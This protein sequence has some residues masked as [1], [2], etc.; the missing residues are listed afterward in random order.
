MPGF[1][2]KIR[3]IMTLRTAR[4]IANRISHCDPGPAPKTIGIGPMKTIPPMLVEAPCETIVAI[5]TSMRPIIIAKNPRM[6]TV[7]KSR[8]VSSSEDSTV[9]RVSTMTFSSITWTGS[10]KL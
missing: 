2:R 3:N 8:P 1:L 4:I 5:A 6:K 10:A 7:R 9:L